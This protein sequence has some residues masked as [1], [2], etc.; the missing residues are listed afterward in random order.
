MDESELKSLDYLALDGSF[1]GVTGSRRIIPWWGKFVFY[2]FRK[3]E[4]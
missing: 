3:E 4:T 1:W 2:V